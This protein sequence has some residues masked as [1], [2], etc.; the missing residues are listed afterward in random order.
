MPTVLGTYG[1]DDF[2]CPFLNL[3]VFF[4]HLALPL[5]FSRCL[6]LLLSSFFRQ[7]CMFQKDLRF[8][9]PLVLGVI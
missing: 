2:H 6:T 3:C 5:P 8:M 9:F 1:R 7:I 4:V